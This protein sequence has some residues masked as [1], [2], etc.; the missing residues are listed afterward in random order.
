MDRS[1]PSRSDQHRTDPPDPTAPGLLGLAE[2]GSLPDALVRLGI[3]RLCAQRLREERAGGLQ[4]QYERHRQ[5]IEQLRDSP[6]AI[7]TDAANRQHYELPARFF[8]DCLGARLKYSCCYYPR[9]DET[10]DQAEEAMLALYAQRAELADGQYILEL[11]CGW[12]SLTLWMAE[13]YPN[14]QIVAVSNS[15]PQREHIQAQCAQRGLHNVLVL[16]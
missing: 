7:H 16:T 15:R 10:L 1:D 9:G 3:R 2:R 14:A 6:V 8:F 12:G 13:R 5:R 11:G 4:A